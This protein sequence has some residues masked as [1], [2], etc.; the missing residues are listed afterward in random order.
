MLVKVGARATE[1]HMVTMTVLA[2]VVTR[3]EEMIALVNLERMEDTNASVMGA[4]WQ[5][6]GRGGGGGSEGRGGSG[7]GGRSLLQQ[8]QWSRHGRIRPLME[9]RLL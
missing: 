6:Q 7:L 5:R 1:V 8:Q 3:V 9:T 4:E 2:R